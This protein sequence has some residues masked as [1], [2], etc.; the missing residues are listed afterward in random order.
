MKAL[1]GRKAINLVELKELTNEAKKD[2][3]KGTAYEVI[4]EIEMS[5][6]AFREFAED[7][8]KDQ[9]WIESSEGGPN[10]NGEVKCI[11][12]INRA[13]RERI[14]VNPEGYSYPRYTAIE[15]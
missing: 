15:E 10:K 11:R 2:G 6:A 14:L 12:V 13:T 8:Q 3:V 9:P 4:R 7:L 1:F 5:P